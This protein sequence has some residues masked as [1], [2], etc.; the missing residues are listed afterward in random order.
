M[1]FETFVD[2]SLFA[3]GNFQKSPE[4]VICEL[5]EQFDRGEITEQEYRLGMQDLRS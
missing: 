3:A 2:D 5:T 4:Q 1:T